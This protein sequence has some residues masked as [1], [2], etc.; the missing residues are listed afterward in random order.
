[1]Q[2]PRGLSGSKEGPSVP[3]GTLCTVPGITSHGGGACSLHSLAMPFCHP[4]CGSCVPWYG[5]DFIGHLS[6]GYRS[7]R[8]YLIV[9]RSRGY[10]CL[11]L[12][13]KRGHLGKTRALNPS[14]GDPQGPGRE[15]LQGRPF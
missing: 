9:H 11:H 6:R 13:F 3:M 15:S 10:G 12:D 5:M 14:P 8:P 7:M 2:G 4:S 1:M